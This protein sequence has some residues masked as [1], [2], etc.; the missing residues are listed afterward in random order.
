MHGR[1]GIHNCI[2]SDLTCCVACRLVPRWSDQLRRLQLQR[3]LQRAVTPGTHR[4]TS[5]VAT[6]LAIVNTDACV[7][8]CELCIVS[9]MRSH[10]ALLYG[11][12]L[13][14][15]MDSPQHQACRNA[16]SS[17]WLHMHDVRLLVVQ[18]GGPPHKLE[19]IETNM[20]TTRDQHINKAVA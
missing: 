9:S 18:G 17:I 12:P 14:A 8:L 16:R 13:Q 4:P 5:F 10:V 2:Y 20:N 11:T 7:M 19:C 6:L 1:A 15:Q 3:L